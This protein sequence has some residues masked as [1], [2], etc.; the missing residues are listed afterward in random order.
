MATWAYRRPGWRQKARVVDQ[1]ECSEEA[2]ADG[3]CSGRM[4]PSL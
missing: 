3:D 2:Q 4:A 1:D